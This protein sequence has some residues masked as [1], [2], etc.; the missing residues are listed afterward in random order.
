MH[1]APDQYT[2]GPEETWVKGLRQGQSPPSKFWAGKKQYL[3]FQTT[4]DYYL[5]YPADF[6][7]TLHQSR[8]KV[9]KPEGAVSNTK[10]YKFH[11]KGKQPSMK[12]MTNQG[13]RMKFF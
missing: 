8:W 12:T 1:F 11:S 4:V 10:D 6:P 2:S 5:L 9:E 3:L 13:P 7:M